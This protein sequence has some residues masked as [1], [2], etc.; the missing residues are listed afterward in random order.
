MNQS[1]VL[2]NYNPYELSLAI[3]HKDTNGMWNEINPESK[4]YKYIGQNKVIHDFIDS[5]QNDILEE[6]SFNVSAINIRYSGRK[7]DFEDFVQALDKKLVNCDLD[8]K[9]DFYPKFPFS[10]STETLIKVNECFNLVHE[11]FKGHDELEEKVDRFES[12][13]DN[14]ANLYVFGNY[15]VGKSTLINALV[16]LD[17]LPSGLD[18]E[19]SVIT[20]II[21]GDKVSLTVNYENRK[22]SSF[23]WDDEK[24]KFRSC[25]RE[26][27]DITDYLSLSDHKWYRQVNNIIHNINLSNSKKNDDTPKIISVDLTIPFNNPMMCNGKISFRI[28]DTPGSNSSN[29]PEN[30]EMLLD[31]IKSQTN[32]LPI[33]VLDRRSIDAKDVDQLIKDINELNAYNDF[34]ISHVVKVFNISDKLDRKDLNTPVKS[35]DIIEWGNNKF[36]F[37]SSRYALGARNTFYDEYV[38][39][40]YNAKK[41]YFLAEYKDNTFFNISKLSEYYL[42]NTNEKSAQNR[43]N[44]H[45]IQTSGF[46]MLEDN[47]RLFIEKYHKPVIVKTKLDHLLETIEHAKEIKLKRKGKQEEVFVSYE[48]AKEEVKAKIIA[49]V[50]ST[51]IE[52]LGSDKQE[53]YQQ[54]LQVKLRNV[55]EKIP[56]MVEKKWKDFRGSDD[57]IQSKKEKLYKAISL[58]CNNYYQELFP[59]IKSWLEEKA[60]D[61]YLKYVNDVNQVIKTTNDL[62]EDTLVSLLSINI[63]QQNFNIRNTDFDG[64]IL[65]KFFVNINMFL[66]L[67]ESKTLKKNVI[68]KF[69]AEFMRDCYVIPIRNIEKQLKYACNRYKEVLFN[70]I[71]TESI[72]LKSYNDDLSEL[73]SEIRDLD[74]K[75]EKLVETEKTLSTLIEMKGEMIN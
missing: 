2:I 56:V 31:N 3:K 59:E 73:V 18:T 63:D 50:N 37:V 22:S 28:V 34:G 65:K 17:I 4:L 27:D 58:E 16:G 29:L 26:G 51:S 25:S 74:T 43:T 67:K 10:S 60:N 13:D 32:V 15:S 33:L 39:S 47:I 20:T 61:Y 41:D 23:S 71:E 45:I 52:K 36:M 62:D 64:N 38:Q 57:K 5:L 42:S 7:S 19:T 24:Q 9:T 46:H 35:S 75:V 66:N 69:R 72:E 53:Y 55:E 54:Y 44:Y 40:D 30:S 12:I 11:T 49:D 70:N 48:I 68:N 1:N 21:Q 8:V 14:V 6:F